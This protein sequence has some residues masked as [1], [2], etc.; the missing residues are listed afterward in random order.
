MLY[1]LL[2]S[3]CTRHAAHHRAPATMRRELRGPCPEE[4]ELREGFCI[5]LPACLAN[6]PGKK[7]LV[8]VALLV[9]A[10]KTKQ[11][12]RNRLHRSPIILPTE[13]CDV[14]Q[15]QSGTNSPQVNWW[16]CRN[17][18]YGR[19]AERRQRRGSGGPG[20]GRTGPRGAVSRLYLR[21]AYAELYSIQCRVFAMQPC[22]HNLTLLS[23]S[24]HLLG[25][26]W[27]VC[28]ASL[29]SES[30]QRKSVNGVSYL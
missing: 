26:P 1:T 21:S 18:L 20:R 28:A 13:S 10:S 23:S 25:I 4:H 12:S 9:A 27:V 2:C 19:P 22:L 14:S 29:N 30:L 7:L 8:N 17:I 5:V 3:C 11:A 15:R 6:L 24:L 16:I